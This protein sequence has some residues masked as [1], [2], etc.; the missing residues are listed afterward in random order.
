[1]PDV[2]TE[3]TDRQDKIADAIPAYV[4]A[5]PERD[6]NAS[7]LAR[8]AKCSTRDAWPVLDWLVAADMIAPCGRGGAW[9]RYRARRFGEIPSRMGR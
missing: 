3:L 1:M 4:D 2:T 8:V 9:I 5:R 6:F 7:Q